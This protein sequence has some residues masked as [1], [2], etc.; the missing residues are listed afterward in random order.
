MRTL[1]AQRVHLY[2][3]AAHLQFDN[4]MPPREA[5]KML[6]KLLTERKK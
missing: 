4:R 5:A 2:E 6:E 1:Y 3:A